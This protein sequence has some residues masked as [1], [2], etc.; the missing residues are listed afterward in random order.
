MLVGFRVVG[1]VVFALVPI[2]ILGV[3][4]TSNL[5]KGPVIADKLG[6][7]IVILTHFYKWVVLVLNGLT[8]QQGLN[9]ISNFKLLSK[10]W[11]QPLLILE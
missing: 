8:L 2:Y 3:V 4:I 10:P 1:I 9:L 11:F 7:A 6:R 5:I